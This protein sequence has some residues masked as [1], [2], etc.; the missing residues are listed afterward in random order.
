MDFISR[1]KVA[2]AL[3][4]PKGITVNC[5]SLTTEEWSFLFAVRMQEHLQL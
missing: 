5:Q 3:Q 1:S 2:N 4:N